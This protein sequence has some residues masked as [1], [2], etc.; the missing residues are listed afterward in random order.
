MAGEWTKKHPAIENLTA[1]Q[2]QLDMDGCEVAVSRQ[3]VD[4]TLEVATALY[5]A[6][7]AC[8]DDLAAEIEA[9]RH[10]EVARRI[11]RDL[12]TVVKARAALAQARG[13]G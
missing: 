11:E 10:G 4:E 1:R 12:Q 9:R 3:A 5:E 7:E 2:R 6:L 13:E 8:A